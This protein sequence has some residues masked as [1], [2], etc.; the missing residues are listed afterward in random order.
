MEAQ[1][2]AL[3]MPIELAADTFA[4]RA[5]LRNLELQL[6]CRYARHRR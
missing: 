5:H 6:A 3:P 1:P 4:Y 2:I